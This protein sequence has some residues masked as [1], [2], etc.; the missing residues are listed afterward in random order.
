LRTIRIL[1]IT[2]S[3]LSAEFGAGQAAIQLTQALKALGHDVVLW[4]PHP[5]PQ[6]KWWQSLQQM[7]AKVDAFIETQEPFD[8]IDSPAG[9][10]TKR[11]RE[12]AVVVAR[13]TQPDILYLLYGLTSQMR[14]DVKSLIRTPFNYLY[15]LF[16]LT[17]VLQ[18]WRRASCIFCLGTLELQW[19]KRW[20]PWWREK[21][22]LYMN[23][24]SESDQAALATIRSQRK[25]HC[26]DGL[27]FL[28]IGRWVSHKGPDVLLD[29]IKQ[30]S[31]LR[32][33]DI[34]T[35]A[36]CGLEA[37][38]HCPGALIESGRL[39]I[40]PSFDRRDLYSLLGSNDIG[41][42]TSKVEGWGLVLNEMLESGMHV[43]STQVGGAPD[44]EPFFKKQLYRFP[45]S[46]AEIS[47]LSDEANEL[48]NYYEVFAWEKIA[49][50]YMN[51]LK[52]RLN[53][54]W[55]I[56]GEADSAAIVQQ[57]ESPRGN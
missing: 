51:S 35:I 52:D 55:Q 34:F 17:L 25:K 43:F 20:F 14:W 33:Q 50:A 5:L 24:L 37:E 19:M 6:T 46:P 10:I 13:S 9:F 26:A 11:M 49:G 36:G 18:G 53:P 39:K 29:F 42:F 48:K 3:P 22:F 27:H 2:H 31:T 45:P 41:L 4:S 47:K 56:V 30:W 21:L 44:L 40:I 38:K 7:R 23:A 54:D 15:T 12:S 8:V 16:H 57:V 32:P 1:I 28:W